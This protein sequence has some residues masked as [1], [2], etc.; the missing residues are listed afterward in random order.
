MKQYNLSKA[1]DKCRLLSKI[2]VIYK[3]LVGRKTVDFC[4]SESRA[5]AQYFRQC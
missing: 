4:M 1:M 3:L 2:Y 5:R